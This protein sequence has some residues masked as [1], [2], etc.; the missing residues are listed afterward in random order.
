MLKAKSLDIS[1]WLRLVFGRIFVKKVQNVCC[2]IH[3]LFCSKTNWEF[4]GGFTPM[5][6]LSKV[7]W[8][9]LCVLQ[10]VSDAIENFDFDNQVPSAIQ[11]GNNIIKVIIWKS[12]REP[13]LWNRIWDVG[14]FWASWQYWKKKLGPIMNFWGQFF[15]VFRAKKY[16]FWNIL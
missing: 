16:F 7:N 11:I 9:F 12:R 8:P 1:Y 2:S 10:F 5:D 13:F 6:I 3:I 4:W 14:W 15:Y